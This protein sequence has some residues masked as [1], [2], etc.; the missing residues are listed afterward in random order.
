MP[1][2]LAALSGCPLWVSDPPT[3]VETETETSSTGPEV[4]FDCE[5]NAY[6]CSCRVSPSGSLAVPYCSPVVTH[7]YRICCASSDWPKEGTCGCDVMSCSAL[8]KDQCECEAG[9]TDGYDSCGDLGGSCAT[10]TGCVGADNPA[11]CGAGEEFLEGPCSVS[12][13]PCPDG[14]LSVAYCD[15]DP[16]G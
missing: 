15:Y 4:R 12:S 8:G 7:N 3:G 9:L 2:L 1:L 11:E 10:V 14:Q 5:E 13:V 16:E 6:S